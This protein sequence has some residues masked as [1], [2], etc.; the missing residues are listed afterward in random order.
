MTNKTEDFKQLKKDYDLYIEEKRIFDRMILLNF[1][2][3][4]LKCIKEELSYE[5]IIKKKR[6]W[7]RS[8]NYHN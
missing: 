4:E 6:E 7:Y 1:H 2:L 5:E 3:I 8:N